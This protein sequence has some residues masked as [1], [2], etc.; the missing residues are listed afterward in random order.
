MCLSLYVNIHTESFAHH[1]GTVSPFARNSID[2]LLPPWRNGTFGHNE[3]CA[4]PSGESESN[5]A[6][7][8]RFGKCWGCNCVNSSQPCNV[9]QTCLWF[10]QGEGFEHALPVSSVW[11]LMVLMHAYPALRLLDRLQDVRRRR[12]QPQYTHT[13]I[14]G[15]N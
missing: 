7:R 3:S 6:T 2:R 9:G 10:S 13:H 14:Q 12:V 4:H 11:L 1:T 5:N 8:R 15:L